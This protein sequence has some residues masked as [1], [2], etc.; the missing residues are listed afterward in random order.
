MLIAL[1]YA[2]KNNNR[3]YMLAVAA[4]LIPSLPWLMDIPRD[5]KLMALLSEHSNRSEL[6]LGLG[7]L[8][9]VYQAEQAKKVAEAEQAKKQQAENFAHIAMPTE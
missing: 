6:F 3:P 7:Y 8:Y 4:Y 5:S 9:D 2:V 1:G